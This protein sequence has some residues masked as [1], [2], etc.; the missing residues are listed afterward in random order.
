[1][2]GNE[3][4]SLDYHYSD[5]IVNTRVIH[6]SDEITAMDSETIGERLK[7]LRKKRG[8]TQSALASAAKISQ[9][10]VGNIE[11]GLRGYGESIVDLAAALQVTP[12]YLRLETEEEGRVVSANDPEASPQIPADA[13]LVNQA[14]IKRVWVVG[15]GSGGLP[16]RIWTDGDYPVGVTDEYGEVS[17]TDPHAFLTKVFGPSMIPVF[18]PGNFALVEPGT[19]PE[20]EDHVLVRLR[21]GETII[22]KLVS[23]RDG[24]TF[25]SYNDP[26]VLHFE[27]GEVTWVYYIAH[28]VPRRKIKSR[29]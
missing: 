27:Q 26:Q 3:R 15:K 25:S 10:T 29:N 22:K 2:V 14:K 16:E 8:L 4:P 12:E 24:F 9:G 11:S 20:I 21:S 18:T 1:M 19:E 23:R 17:S 5:S 7:R 13:M 28:P 6:K